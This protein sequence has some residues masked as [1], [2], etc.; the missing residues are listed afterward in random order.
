VNVEM[1]VKKSYGKPLTGA[2]AFLSSFSVEEK[3]EGLGDPP[4]DKHRRRR[5]PNSVCFLCN[6]GCLGAREKRE[7]ATASRRSRDHYR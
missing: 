1:A 6:I 4:L 2:R 5:A 3:R 7:S